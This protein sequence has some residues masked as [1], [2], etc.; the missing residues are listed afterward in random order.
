VRNGYAYTKGNHHSIIYTDDNGNFSEKVVSFWEATE[1]CLQ[2]LASKGSI[3]PLIDTRPNENGWRVYTTLQIND[4]FMLGKDP[5]TVDWNNLHE[6]KE[7][8]K[9]I[10]RVQWMSKGD[11]FFRHIYE[12]TITRSN[13]FACR[14]ITSLKKFAEIYKLPVNIIGRILL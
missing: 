14:R 13:N 7:A 12:S 6:V 5:S 3:N 4:L 11:Y 10:F 1:N 8:V 2:N 9:Y